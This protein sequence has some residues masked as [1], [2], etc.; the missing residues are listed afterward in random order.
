M[1][2]EISLI[3]GDQTVR[4]WRDA[5]ADPLGVE[6]MELRHPH[7]ELLLAQLLLVNKDSRLNGMR[8]PAKMRCRK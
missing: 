7:Q 3:L 8:N 4:L 5:R 6:S 2:K 1:R